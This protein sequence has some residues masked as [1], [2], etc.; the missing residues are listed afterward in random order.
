MNERFSRAYGTN[1]RVYGLNVS[2][3]RPSAFCRLS[4]TFCSH[5][6]I[7]SS[8]SDACIREPAESSPA[9][10]RDRSALRDI[11]RHGG[12]SH[13]SRRGHV[14]VMPLMGPLIGR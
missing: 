10:V 6:L 11:A 8:L 2:S 5:A 1:G 4:V 13:G 9:R 7:T 3:V 14:E 12:R